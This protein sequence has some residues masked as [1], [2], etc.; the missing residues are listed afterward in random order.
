MIKSIT[1][2]NQQPDLNAKRNQISGSYRTPM[3]LNR[4]LKA[5]CSGQFPTVYKNFSITPI[6]KIWNNLL[7]G[8]GNLPIHRRYV[9]ENY[10]KVVGRA[11]HIRVPTSEPG[12]IEV[13]EK[14]YKITLPKVNPVTTADVID[15]DKETLGLYCSEKDINVSNDVAFAKSLEATLRESSLLSLRNQRFKLLTIEEAF[16]SLRSNTSSCYPLFVKKSDEEARDR[17][18]KFVKDVFS[19]K[20]SLDH[21]MF[22]LWNEIVTI[23]HRITLKVDPFRPGETKV[24][25]T[26]KIRQVFGLPFGPLVLETMFMNRVIEHLQRKS[27][28]FAFGLTRPEISKRIERFFEISKTSG[29]KIVVSG[30]LD[31]C[32]ASLSPKLVLL[33]FSV[34]KSLLRVP[35]NLSTVYDA[36]TYY[37][38]YTP[39]LAYD[40]EVK[41]TV[42]GNKSGMK[43]T[44]VINCFVLGLAL[45][46]YAFRHYGRSYKPF[47][48]QILGDDFICAIKDKR[49]FDVLASCF[50]ELGLKLNKRKTK[51]YSL[52]DQTL[53]FLG[54]Q[55][56]SVKGEYVPEASDG[57]IIGHCC[58]PERFIPHLHGEIRTVAR[59]CS[60]VFQIY[61]GRWIMDKI[62]RYDKGLRRLFE[63][64]GIRVNVP[65]I[66]DDSF[67]TGEVRTIQQYFS[68]GWKLF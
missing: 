8:S 38:T 51:L 31:S 45:N 50:Q 43:T 55:W 60:I 40:S 56:I 20:D 27:M 28:I 5:I 21:I 49:D 13:F 62:W 42:G 24:T 4:H 26:R 11:K 52:E 1:S 63:R 33:F 47:E 53:T 23:F 36:L 44:T 41:F 6:L 48:V 19:R 58:Y 14:M 59:M 32:D 65:V 46:Y 12:L 37:L 68:S 2:A 30:D 10:K 15:S 18:T 3:S 25:F 57:W 39:I 66:I 61:R 9:I 7:L 64:E 17:A 54:F 22:H 35:S 16:N 34:L 67:A 29:F